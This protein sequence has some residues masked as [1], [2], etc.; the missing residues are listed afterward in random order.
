M[1]S[2][3]IGLFDL[4]QIREFQLQQA[5]AMR[6][7][8]L[9]VVMAAQWRR[10]AFHVMQLVVQGWLQVWVWVCAYLGV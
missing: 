2:E 7:R 3:I 6:R 1:N 8:L 9:A 10:K 4:A 5:R